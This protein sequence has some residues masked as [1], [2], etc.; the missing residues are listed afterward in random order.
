M[1]EVPII[2]VSCHILWDFLWLAWLCHSQQCCHILSQ[3][4][5]LPHFSL[6][7]Q[8]SSLIIRKK[9]SK[10]MH[11]WFYFTAKITS[12][13]LFTKYFYTLHPIV[14]YSKIFIVIVIINLFTKNFYIT[15]NAK[16]RKP[17]THIPIRFIEIICIMKSIFHRNKCVCKKKISPCT[18]ASILLIIPLFNK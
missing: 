2:L 16:Q 9:S 6:R 14:C 7:I 10:L 13:T 11:L 5:L 3:L 4:T 17:Y 18:H 12:Y 1:T 15:F 8:N